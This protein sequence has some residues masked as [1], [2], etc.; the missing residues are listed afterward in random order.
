MSLNVK[1]EDLMN[2]IL[3]KLYDTLTN[4]DET[5][6]NSKDNYLSW[7]TP[8]IPYDPEDFKFLKEGF[9]GYEKKTELNDNLQ[10]SEDDENS[11]NETQDIDPI[12]RE[13]QRADDAFGKYNAAEAFSR[14]A[15]FVPDASGINPEGQITT[16][17]WNVE[18]KLSQVYEEVLTFSKVP[19]DEIDEKTKE[20]IEKL[21]GYLV[22]KVKVK[23]LNDALEEVE[24]EKIVDSVIKQKYIEKMTAYED[25]VLAYNT[26]RINALSGSSQMA[27]HDWSMNGNIYRNKVKAAMYDWISNGYKTTYERI[28]SF[29][30]QVEGRS[31]MLLKEK[32]KDDFEKSKITS[33]NSGMEFMYASLVPA[34]FVNEGGWTRFS[35][36]QNDYS[37]N[38]KSKSRGFSGNTGVSFGLFSIGAS[39]GYQKNESSSSIDMSNFSLE[40]E[41]CQ[42]QIVRPWLNLN[43]LKSPYWCFDPDSTTHGDA[44]LSDGKTPPEGR[45]PVI[46]TSCIFIRDLKLNFANSS[47]VKQDMSESV[48]AGGSVGYGPFR[49]GGSY[50]RADAEGS[51]DMNSDS[52]GIHVDGMQLIGFK[53][54]VLPQTPNPEPSV[55]NWV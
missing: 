42:V 51:L 52:Q 39:G 30:S 3:G 8:G 13:K 4:G 22:K 5:V 54:H 47:Q 10:N 7:C 20:K 35:F 11:E 25:A 2:S 6:P 23:E 27:I 37:S 49:L 26:K 14:L 32:Y 50:S 45:S 21:R 43:F 31:M 19:N 46:T 28:S 1:P 38:Y 12:E 40:F 55:D 29:I 44:Q 18:N 9:R 41:M 17:V 34:G 48:N 36:T 33:A 15:D 24:V 53:C 16:N